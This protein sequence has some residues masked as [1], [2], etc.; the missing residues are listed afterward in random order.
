[1]G[2]SKMGALIC[3]CHSVAQCVVV[4]GTVRGVEVC[5][6]LCVV[7]GKGRHGEIIPTCSTHNF[8]TINLGET[9]IGTYL[10]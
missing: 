1:M 4:W 3:C 6:A 8:Q 9:I 10:Q 5:E 2:S 7:W